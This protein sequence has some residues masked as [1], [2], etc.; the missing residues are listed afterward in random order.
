[1]FGHIA[2]KI[3][4][5]YSGSIHVYSGS[6]EPFDIGEIEKDPEHIGLNTEVGRL[7]DKFHEFK[8][9][10]SIFDCEWPASIP[11]PA[12]RRP[13]DDDEQTA[14]FD[15]VGKAMVYAFLHE[16]K[17][18]QFSSDSEERPAEPEEEMRCDEY[19]RSFLFDEVEK[20]SEITGDNLQKVVSKRAM[21]VALASFL[22]LELTPAETRYGSD[23]HPPVID[24]IRHV[25]H[26]P[27]L[28]QDDNYWLYLG[29]ILMTKC[30]LEG[31]KTTAFKFDS[32]KQ[33]CEKVFEEL[34][35][36]ALQPK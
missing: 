22:I 4:Y 8:S 18:I 23:S 30:R 3:F 33:F 2:W 19:A 28:T 16:I 35:N 24:R 31:A 20:Y 1:M 36:H 25:L 29:S 21:A 15:L 6:G 27:S 10:E 12:H 34:A 13:T 5:L 26:F 11:E 17:H 32:R 14:I 7:L 9:A